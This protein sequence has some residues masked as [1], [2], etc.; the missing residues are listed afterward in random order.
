MSLDFF[1]MVFYFTNTGVRKVIV[2]RSARGG[3]VLWK[4]LSSV[5]DGDAAAKFYKN[6]VQSVSRHLGPFGRNASSRKTTT[7]LGTRRPRKVTRSA[8]LATQ[9]ILC[10]A[11]RMTG[12]SA[13]L[14]SDI[15]GRR[16]KCDPK[17]K[18]ESYHEYRRGFAKQ[19]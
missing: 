16:A 17:T 4:R 15:P 11:T 9:S 8:R 13:L 10:R 6:D 19:Q 12:P 7:P 3:V 18:K 5:W 1:Q 14:C 2:N